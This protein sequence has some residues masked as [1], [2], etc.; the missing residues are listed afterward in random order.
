LAEAIGKTTDAQ[1]FALEA[2]LEH[3]VALNAETLRRLGLP[4]GEA[5]QIARKLESQAAPRG[6]PAGRDIAIAVEAI[7]AARALLKGGPEVQIVCTAPFGT[8]VPVRTTFATSIE[9][10]RTAKQEILVVGYLF[11]KGAKQ[12]L[13][14]LAAA[15]RARAVAVTLVGNRLTEHLSVLKSVWDSQSC[16][17]NLLSREVDPTDTL[18]ALH[19]KL[20]VCDR[21]DA[22]ITSANLSSHG[23]HHNIEIGIRVKSAE[24]SSLVDFIQSMAS[25]GELKALLWN[26]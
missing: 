7:R 8:G 19:A 18:A 13:R 3:G 2:E 17:P 14:E 22:L 6:L 23:L 24:M 10:I 12:V 5:V 25:K 15:G 26:A 20:L 9:M 4:T 21:H 11:T 1:L 16:R